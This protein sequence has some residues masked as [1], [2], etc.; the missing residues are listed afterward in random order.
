M[1]SMRAAVEVAATKARMEADAQRAVVDMADGI[2]RLAGAMEVE[3]KLAQQRGTVSRRIQI[4]ILALAGAALVVAIIALVSYLEFSPAWPRSKRVIIVLARAVSPS[5]RCRKIVIVI[6]IVGVLCPRIAATTAG[7]MP[8]E[9]M[10]EAAVWRSP[11]TVSRRNPAAFA[12][13]TNRS[14]RRS[15]CHGCPISSV[16]T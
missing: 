4:A 14:P 15:G 9:S 8:C 7:S 12:R 5:N 2:E 6:V 13:A 1:E 10:I 3:S 11:C 16:N